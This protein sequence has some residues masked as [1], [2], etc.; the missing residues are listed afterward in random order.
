MPAKQKKQFH[1]MVGNIGLFYVC[2]RLSCRGWN[3]LPTSRNARGVDVIIY[4]QDAQI[5]HTIQVKTLSR[6]NAVPLG[7]NL[8]TLFADFFAVC[9]RTVEPNSGADEPN[10]ECFVLRKE[11]LL[12]GKSEWGKGKKKGYW[13]EC[14]DYENDTFRERWDKIGHG[15]I[16]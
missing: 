2:Y 15:T 7:S 1:L 14:K 3:V 12:N 16:P 8:D 11:E 4:S 5:M 10:P 13:L 6:R 9:V